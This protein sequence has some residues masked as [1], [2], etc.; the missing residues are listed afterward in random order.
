MLL[1]LQFSIYLFIFFKSYC[2]VLISLVFNF[3]SRPWTLLSKITLRGCSTSRKTGMAT[4]NGLQVTWLLVV[5]LV[6]LP[7]SLSTLWI[8][9]EPVLQMMPRL[10][11]R[12]EGGNSMALSMSTGRPSNRMVLLAFTVASTFLVLASL[13][14]VVYTLECMTHWS[15]CS[16]L[17]I[18][19]LVAYSWI[20]FIY[21]CDVIMQFVIFNTY[22][23]WRYHAIHD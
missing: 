4:G 14:T 23:A 15:Q 2:S 8:M 7:C 20:H 6:P 5:L 19:R 21:T 12:E 10:R 17:E 1:A 22:L 13:C 18:C 11:R 16:W 9:P 3:S